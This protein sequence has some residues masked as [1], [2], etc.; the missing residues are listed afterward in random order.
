MTTSF[1]G[2]G[3]RRE[4]ED[5]KKKSCG[6]ERK[7]NKKEKKN[8][9]GEST[10]SRSLAFRAFSR[11]ALRWVTLLAP[12]CASI[13]RGEEEEKKRDY[14]KNREKKKGPRFS[15]NEIKNIPDIFKFWQHTFLSVA[16]M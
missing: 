13:W 10:F 5:R 6:D 16:L 11:A 2:R 4:K 9:R 3:Y 1:I 15:S 14:A 12:P 8:K 7:K